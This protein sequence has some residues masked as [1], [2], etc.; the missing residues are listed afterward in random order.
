MSGPGTQSL[1]RAIDQ[2]RPQPNLQKGCGF[3]RNHA[4]VPL[5]PVVRIDLTWPGNLEGTEKGW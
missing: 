2:Q 4:A 1:V 5:H 3:F